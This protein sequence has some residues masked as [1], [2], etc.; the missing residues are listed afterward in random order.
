MKQNLI[1]TLE[2]LPFPLRAVINFRS[3]PDKDIF[4]A[5]V[6]KPRIIRRP[7]VPTLVEGLCVLK[8][9]LDVRTQD[10]PGIHQVAF[11][12]A[13]QVIA[14]FPNRQLTGT[15]GWLSPKDKDGRLA[16]S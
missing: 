6:V 12:V 3:F 10:L 7:P 8:N 15:G 13:L 4:D 9:F 14:I 11:G 2:R 5:C 16:R 1:G